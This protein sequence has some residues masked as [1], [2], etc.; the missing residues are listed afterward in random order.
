[1]R[2]EPSEKPIAW[3]GD[4]T[5]AIIERSIENFDTNEKGEPITLLILRPTDYFKEKN[6][7]KNNELIDG[8]LLSF[9]V[10]AKLIIPL[11]PLSPENPRHF[12][13]VDFR[14]KHTYFVRFLY[15]HKCGKNYP[16]VFDSLRAAESTIFSKN[17][18]IAQLTQEL[19]NVSGNLEIG[20]SEKTTDNIVD[21][22]YR[23]LSKKLDRGSIDER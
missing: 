18:Q 23:R 15:C 2:I 13:G 9:E 4:G 6:D 16:N 7:I 22:L 3:F 12:I 11:N 19:K 10:P 14:K 21:E 20:L 1:M 5:E 17:I 8:T